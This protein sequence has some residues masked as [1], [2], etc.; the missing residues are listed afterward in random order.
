[1][2]Q[3]RRSVG[4]VLAVATAA[5]ALTVAACGGDSGSSGGGGGGAGAGGKSTEPIKV[6]FAVDQTGLYSFAGVPSKKGATL[7]ADEINAAGG[8]NGRKIELVD[9]DAGSEQQQTKSLMTKYA[10]DPSFLAVLGPSSSAIAPSI[11]PVVNALK[12]PAVGPTVS[13]PVYTDNNEW[14]FKMGANPDGVGKTLCEVIKNAGLKKVAIM[15]TRDNVG[16][17][18]YKDTAVKCLPAA[19]AQVVTTQSASD[20]TDDYSSFISNIK[21]KSPDAIFTLLS[22]QRSAQFEVQA[23]AA[24]IP[25]TVGFFGPNTVTGADFMKIGKK[26]VEGTVGVTE[27]FPGTPTDMNKK[28]VAA[29]TA[30]F[31]ATPDNYAAQGYASMGLVA[32]GIKSAGGNVTREAIRDGMLK[33]ANAETVMGQGKVTITPEHVSQYDLLT[34]QVKNGKLILYKAPGA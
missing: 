20:A 33:V 31:G 9:G 22:G 10:S 19:G 28:F 17:V 32:A 23:R 24:G 3:M 12:I 14:T 16:Q 15:V 34:V 29:Y 27:Y 25:S 30:K 8:I 1:M 5:M 11:A 2:A 21:S 18:G 6:G 26:D 4:P 7:A 13:S